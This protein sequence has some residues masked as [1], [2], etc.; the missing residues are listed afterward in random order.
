MPVFPREKAISSAK[1]QK[2]NL[3]LLLQDVWLDGKSQKSAAEHKV[4]FLKE[5][6]LKW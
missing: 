3:H 6:N 1:T 5:S 2:N 4:D